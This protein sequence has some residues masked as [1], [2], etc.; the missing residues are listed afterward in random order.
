MAKEVEYIVDDTFPD[1][2][3]FDNM[4]KE[5]L[6]EEIEYLEEQAKLD[7]EK[8]I[9]MSR[10]EQSEYFKHR[11]IENEHYLEQMRQKRKIS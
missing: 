7:A 3:K 10:E 1:L 4:T 8:C 5:E 11:E 6:Q 2:S 9:G